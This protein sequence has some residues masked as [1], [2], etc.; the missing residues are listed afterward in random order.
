MADP[1]GS[2]HKEK[3][4]HQQHAAKDQFW[5]IATV[6][7][8]LLVVCGA[9][10][11]ASL[12]QSQQQYEPSS[13]FLSDDM[14]AWAQVIPAN[15]QVV[16]E[17]I[18]IK[19]HPYSITLK[20]INESGTS[21]SCGS[22]YSA[23]IGQLVFAD[24]PLFQECSHKSKKS[25]YIGHVKKNKLFSTY[26]KLKKLN[27]EEKMKELEEMP[28]ICC[29]FQS[30]SALSIHSV[31]TF[32]C[33]LGVCN[34][35]KE[36]VHSIGRY[37]N[38]KPTCQ[39]NNVIIQDLLSLLVG[40]SETLKK[41]KQN[42]DEIFSTAHEDVIPRIQRRHEYI[43]KPLNILS[44]IKNNVSDWK[45]LIEHVTREREAQE[46]E[47]RWNVT[48][49]TTQIP[50]PLQSVKLFR[51]LSCQ[52]HANQRKCLS[53]L[54]GAQNCEHCMTVN[55]VLNMSSKCITGKKC[56]KAVSGYLFAMNCG[57]RSVVNRTV[58]QPAMKVRVLICCRPGSGDECLIFHVH[59][60]EH[61]VFKNV[62]F[63]PNPRIIQE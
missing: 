12:M 37:E 51:H 56:S 49:I 21:G 46:D 14:D 57:E 2:T 62:R 58:D 28:D 1:S 42:Y 41:Q 43:G 35:H 33:S 48:E 18:N 23:V 13:N 55:D 16:L 27:W 4:R 38:C 54:C 3:R 36:T 59:S 53:S 61:Q 39:F 50:L 26:Q 31:A 9:L 25:L 8:L 47:A 11:L 40:S 10:C 19:I 32:G 44:D 6:L 45:K 52:L 29:A 34:R 22:T 20:V 24:V 15:M 5:K 63:F 7:L 30:T 60:R 17:K